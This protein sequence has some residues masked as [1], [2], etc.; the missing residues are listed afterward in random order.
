[1]VRFQNWYPSEAGGGGGGAGT[2]ILSEDNVREKEGRG[3][4]REQRS[5]RDKNRLELKT[6]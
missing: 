5:L 3:L 1:M 2:D 6:E 4:G